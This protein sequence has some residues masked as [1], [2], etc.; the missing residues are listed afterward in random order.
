MFENEEAQASNKSNAALSVVD[1]DPHGFGPPG[2][3]SISQ[4]YGSGF[5]FSHKGVER[6]EIMLAK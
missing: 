1:P 3:G 5:F 6:N 2:S 4:R